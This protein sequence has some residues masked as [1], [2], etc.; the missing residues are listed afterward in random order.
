MM[1]DLTKGEGETSSFLN[2]SM[3]MNG[4]YDQG[5]NSVSDN[6]IMKLGM[7]K[8]S[9]RKGLFQKGLK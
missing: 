7:W 4:S 6:L 9:K 3:S 1:K 2:W 8:K 5:F